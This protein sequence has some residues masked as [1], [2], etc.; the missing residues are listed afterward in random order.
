[1]KIFY[2]KYLHH[3]VALCVLLS[4]A[5]NVFIE[6][7]GRGSLFACLRYMYYSPYTFLYN[8]MIVFTTFS[9]AFL[10]KRRIFILTLVSILW[11]TIGITNG[12]ILGFRTTPFTMTDLSLFDAGLKV[13]ST[14]MSP[15]RIA[16]IVGAAAVV[17]ISLV[18]IFIYAPKYKHPV[19][20]RNSIALVLAVLLSITGLTEVAVNR[21]WV[22]VVFGNLNYAYRDFG[23][24]YCFANT[25]LN[26]G[27]PKPDGYSKEEILGIYNPN[28]LNGDLFASAGKVNKTDSGKARPNIVMVQLE[29]FFD[30]TTMVG[31]TFS[32]DPIP[33]FRKLQDKNSSGYLIVPSVGA[34]TANTEFEVMSGMSIQF[35]GPGEYPYKTVLKEETVETVAYDLKELGYWT[36][37]IHNHRG[38]FYGR[39]KVFAN[40]G[41]DTFT[42]VEY[43]DNV[44]KTPKNYAQ[45]KVLTQ[46]IM[47]T[48]QSTD[49]NDFIYAISVQGHGGYAKKKVYENPAITATGITGESEAYALEYYLQQLYEE[50]LFVGELVEAIKG[51]DERTIVVFY[52][53][54]LPP[55]NLSDLDLT[56]QDL[57]K[58]QYVMWSNFPMASE[59]KD[60][61]AYQLSAEVLNRLGISEGYLT[62]YHQNHSEESDYMDNLEALQYDML[63]GEQYIF[64][65]IS[66]F[67]PVNLKMGVREVTIDEIVQVGE[68]YYI[69]GENFTTYSKITLNGQILDTLFLQPTLLG[70]LED[71]DPQDLANLQVSQVQKHTILSTSSTLSE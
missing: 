28:E 44:T 65:G 52:G 12:I 68:N 29:S 70:L 40:M 22:S 34:G 64:D 21:R 18:L 53:D 62:K 35:F 23:I 36:H 26:T 61:Y 38:D 8:T 43:M 4:L 9:I 31:V 30:P 2:R 57:Y 55:L 33:N 63:Y 24:P 10:F 13:V 6:S 67:L 60:L 59:D 56:T 15:V 1:M 32:Q 47:A 17:L 66:P 54:H 25:W 20:Y 45:D 71:V 16:L 58:E 7:L 27:I 37:A 48:L 14:Y 42:S 46:E 41:F 5:I 19:K 49:G 39:H 3:S 51:F 11:L 50:D 69:K